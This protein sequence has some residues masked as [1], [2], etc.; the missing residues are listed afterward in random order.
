MPNR[1]EG[2]WGMRVGLRPVGDAT[3]DSPRTKSPRREF[4]VW[5]GIPRCTGEWLQDPFPQLPPSHSPKLSPVSLPSCLPMLCPCPSPHCP[6]DMLRGMRG[7]RV[8][9]HRMGEE[10]QHPPLSECVPRVERNPGV[11]AIRPSSRCHSLDWLPKV[12]GVLRRAVTWPGPP[13]DHPKTVQGSSRI[14]GS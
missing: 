11:P 12:L 4:T 3:R 8:C 9:L 7:T 14:S 6:W 13:G 2:T 5:R 10:N 1:R